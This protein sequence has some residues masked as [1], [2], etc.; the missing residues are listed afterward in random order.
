MTISYFFTDW[1]SLSTP[2]RWL[3]G[4][5][6]IGLAFFSYNWA[7]IK[8]RWFLSLIHIQTEICSIQGTKIHNLHYID[9]L[10]TLS[11]RCC[12]IKL[13][14]DP[15]ALRAHLYKKYIRT[16]HQKTMNIESAKICHFNCFLWKVRFLKFMNDHLI[17]KHSK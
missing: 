12:Y 11:D 9:L 16:F 4:D 17:I 5:S 6:E 10:R 13:Q 7:K 1:K 2:F 15:D 8:H 14:D 3:F